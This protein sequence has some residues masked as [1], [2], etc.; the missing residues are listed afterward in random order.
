MT[1]ALGHD[2]LHIRSKMPWPW[3]SRPARTLFTLWRPPHDGVGHASSTCLSCLP[4]CRSPVPMQ[5]AKKALWDSGG[6]ASG[7]AKVREAEAALVDRQRELEAARW[8]RI[9]YLEV[10]PELESVSDVL[11]LRG[12]CRALCSIPSMPMGMAQ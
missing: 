12:A 8:Q 2:H 10:R 6:S 7:R 5:A 3:R 4:A 11:S 9:V 1:G